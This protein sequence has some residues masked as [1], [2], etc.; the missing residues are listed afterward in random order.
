MNLTG[1]IWGGITNKKPVVSNLVDP[2][3]L[4]LFTIFFFFF[5]FLIY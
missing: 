3:I 2:Y 5:F 4:Q 1:G